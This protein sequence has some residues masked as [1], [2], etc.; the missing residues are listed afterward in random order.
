MRVNRCCRPE[1][2]PEDRCSVAPLTVHTDIYYRGDIDESGKE[3]KMSEGILN[4]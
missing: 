2:C 1:E 3:D 4:E